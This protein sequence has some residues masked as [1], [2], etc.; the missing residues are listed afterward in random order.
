MPPR[1]TVEYL[2]DKLSEGLGLHWLAGAAAADHLISRNN[3]DSN[4]PSLIG[5]LNLI[6]P[7]RIQVLGAAELASLKKY[8][9]DHDSE[10]IKQLFQ[11][12]CNMI[13]IAENQSPP[14]MFMRMCGEYQIALVGSD[15][16]SHI[17]VT[18]LRHR[19]TRLLTKKLVIHGVMMDVQGIGLLITGDSSVGKSELALELISRGHSL[20][21]DDAPEFLKIAPDLIEARCPDLLQDFLEVRGLGV[22]NIR[23]MYGHTS[24]RR[25]K[26]LKYI[27]HLTSMK[28]GELENTVDR[29][30]PNNR[31]R[32]I[33]GVEINQGTI[34]VA[35]G[36]NLAVIV[37]AAVRNYMLATNGY[38]AADDIIAKQKA[39][40]EANKCD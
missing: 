35:P 9:L 19:L 13:I 8:N 17:I 21:A 31:T 23:R 27:V 14:A 7:N 38:S 33:L 3:S 39:L 36:R 5:T 29:L 1:L 12:E 40:M 32:N 28:P 26:I 18:E 20:V 2:V 10:A 34:P 25:R 30:D 4:R 11:S 22:L 16:S 15:T 24:T 6:S 37:E